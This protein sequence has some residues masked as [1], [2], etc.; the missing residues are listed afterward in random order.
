[1]TVTYLD[2]CALCRAFPFHVHVPLLGS[3]DV[4]RGDVL[5]GSWV[6]SPDEADQIA[7]ILRRAAD[8]ASR[9]RPESET[10]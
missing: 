6:L 3:I 9:P 8:F 4:D 2:R 5:L 10:R 1:M 7:Q